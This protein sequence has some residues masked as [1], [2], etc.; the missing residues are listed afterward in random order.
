MRVPSTASDR[1]R[2]RAGV[3]HV[4]LRRWLPCAL[5]ALT[6][7]GTRASAEV[8]VFSLDIPDRQRVGFEVPLDVRQSGVVRVEADWEGG[9]IL[10]FRIEGP[11]GTVVRR[12][13]PSPQM[14]TTPELGATPARP[15][16]LAL[17]IVGLPA[18]GSGPGH[19]RVHLPDAPEV[20]A[21]REAAMAP[22]PPP[23]PEPEPW[24]ESVSTP[25]NLGP[26]RLAL[27]RT[28]ERLRAQVVLED[29]WTL[30]PDPCRWQEGV[31]RYLADERDRLMRGDDPPSI[32]TRRY[33]REIAAAAAAVESF[34]TTDDPILAGPV[35]EDPRRHRAWFAV[36]ER[37]VL[38]LERQL[39]Q[40]LI[41]LEH[42]FVPELEGLD[43][44]QR[45]VSCLTACQRHFDEVA[46]V[47]LDDASNQRLASTQ[48]EPILAAARAF[49]ALA[50]VSGSGVA[51]AS[52]D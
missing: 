36:R 51:T 24:M 40:L 34:R 6:A 42:G 21:A 22:P 25:A 17:H 27:I 48:W 7:A 33:F 35:P 23:E 39:D 11:A 18:R 52:N 43:W 47:G 5:L 4:L 41:R 49:E 10:S 9:R 16:R 37:R 1:P 8:H 14:L 19:L 45:Y 44:P 29:D 26:D 50:M 12:S 20:I 38:P 13:G 15:I 30:V 32:A 3:I 46:V 31:L 2:A 28:V